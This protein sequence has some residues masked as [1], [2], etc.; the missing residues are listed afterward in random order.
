MFF[1]PTLDLYEVR[2]SRHGCQTIIRTP[3][4]RCGGELPI[5]KDTN[6]VAGT[7]RRL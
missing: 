4:R 2:G 6:V 3:L 5:I 1:A 7:N